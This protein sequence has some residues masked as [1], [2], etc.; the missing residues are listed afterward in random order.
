MQEE[1][2]KEEEGKSKDVTPEIIENKNESDVESVDSSVVK[3]S[4]DASNVEDSGETKSSD[5][6]TLSE[7]SPT[8]DD[9][10]SDDDEHHDSDQLDQEDFD[11]YTKE[12]FVDLV[13]SLSKHDNPFYAE[14]HLSVITPFFDKIR[15]AEFESAKSAYITENGNEDG[16]DFNAGELINRFD[17]NSRLIQDRKHAHLRDKDAQRKAN[18]KKSEEVLEMLRLLVDSEES[19]ASFS[20]FKEIQTEW[21]SIGDV[22]SQFYK[23]LW[24]NYNALINRFY[25]QRSI[26]FELKELDRKKNHEAKLELCERA[27]KL[28]ELDNLK[29]AINTLNELHNEYKHLGPVPDKVQEELW[30]RFKAASDQVYQKRKEY[31]SSLKEVLNENLKKKE[32][33][34]EQIKAFIE[35]D[36]DRIK[37]WNSKTKELLELQKQWEAIGGLPREKSKDI[38]RVFWTNFKLFFHNKNVFF[39]K[40]DE[41]RN[42]NYTQK[43]KLIERAEAI[44]ESTDWVKT[45]NDFKKLQLDWKEIGPVPEKMRN[46]VYAKFKK[47]CDFFFD[48]RRKSSKDAEKDYKDNVKLKRDIIQQIIDWS[49]DAENH[50][51]EFKSKTKEFA[52]IGFVPRKDINLIKEKFTAATNTFLNALSI[53]EEEKNALQM[54]VELGDILNSKNSENILYGKEQNLRKEIH[55]IENDVALWRNNL[56]FFAHSK[57]KNAD[58]LREEVNANI[59]KGE[60]S[61]ALLKAQLKVL[62]SV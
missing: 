38:N 31:V 45:A 5:S 7:Q 25:D 33:L 54:E 17:A 21:K 8:D 3:K 37:A 41:L 18:L 40:L 11:N 42:D 56:E 62:R 51:E 48:N 58:K 20:K 19:S 15:D 44:K 16:F 9:A 32:E 2:V 52:S 12:Q 46:E 13:K 60:E 59:E 50:V 26:Y 35:F 55:K 10:S 27:E 57:S 61:I 23:T 22:P 34:I 43:L 39:K 24:A 29:D 36:S 14:K 53:S 30:N 1:V 47:S 28:V 49:S 6:N 4:V